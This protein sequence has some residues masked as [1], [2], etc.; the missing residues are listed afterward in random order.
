MV[1]FLLVD[2]FL[3]EATPPPLMAGLA[4]DGILGKLHCSGGLLSVFFLM[5]SRSFSVEVTSFNRDKAS[6]L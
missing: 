5:I 3:L 4:E 2:F 1:T 6:L